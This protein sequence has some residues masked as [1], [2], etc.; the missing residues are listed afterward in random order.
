MNADELRSKLLP[1]LLSGARRETRQEL[2]MMGSDREHSLL[3]ALSLT[4]QSLRFTRPPVPSDFAVEHWPRDER[5]MVPDRLRRPILRLLDRSTDDAARALALGLEKQKLRPHPFDLPML[6]GFARR[7]ADRLGTTAQFWVQRETPAEQLRGYFDADEISAENWTEASLR[8]RV[9]FLS[10]LRKQDAGAARKLLEQ[11]W[12]GENPDGRVQLLSVLQA[13]LSQEDKEFLESVK[14]DRAPRVRAIVHRMLAVLSGASGD[15]P[16]L[17]ACMERI[18]RSKTGLLKKRHALKLELPATVKEHETNRWIQEQFADVTLEQLA[19][20]CEESDRELVGA[21]EKDGNLLLALA[22]MASREKRFDLLDAISDELPEA[23]GRMSELN[24][25]DDLEKGRDE[26]GVWATALIKPKKWMPAV[27]FPAWS[28]LH[29]QMEGPLPAAI[30]RDVL[31]SKAC[32]EQLEPEKKG[33]SEFVQVICALCPPELRG[34][35]RAQLEPLEADRKD[36][37]WMLLDILDELE[38]VR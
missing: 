13:E 31:A 19:H 28:W 38:N 30:M 29:R 12:A 26:A 16:A 3:R 35:L 7:Y 18:Q 23:W 4:G 34:L 10:E 36:K 15:N 24:W 32:K 2:L 17:T 5:R 21:A 6:D 9:K 11:S 20:A 27:P 14:K 33:G 8:P 37:G 1:V 25:E 22:L